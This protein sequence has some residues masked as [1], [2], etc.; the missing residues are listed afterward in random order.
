MTRATTRAVLG[1][2]VALVVAGCSSGK[3]DFAGIGPYHVKKLTLAKATGRCEP[4]DLPDG[5]KGTWCFGQP[6]L[7]IGGQ[8]AEVDLYFGG[9]TPDAK[10]IEIQLQ[11]RGCR[12]S[13]LSTWLRTNFGTPADERTA[14]AAWQNANVF[15]LAELPSA[16]GRCIVRFLPRSEQAEFERL[17]QL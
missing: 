17:K 6:A 5:R 12:D 1:L 16:P 11:F 13:E 3:P 15:V 14:R 8:R 2:A 4:T 10:V 7:S 9:T